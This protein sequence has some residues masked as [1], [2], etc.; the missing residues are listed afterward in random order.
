MDS[1]DSTES[2]DRIEHHIVIQA[3]RRR[4]WR[5]LADAEEFG[6][7]FGVNL[8]GQAFVVGQR[9]H[10][11]LVYPGYEHMVFDV[12]IEH[13]VEMERLSYRWH[14][15]AI[16]PSV[17]YAQEPP[18]LVAFTL[19]DAPRN[20]TLLTVVESGFDQVPVHRRL[21]AFRMNSRGWEYRMNNIMQHVAA[22]P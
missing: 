11:P 14:P 17:D 2:P 19:K 9:T 22:Y 10:A 18:T 21:E 7:W 12:I 6:R 15:Y 4:V 16:N 20:S 8:E 3:P 1:T 5:A 13:I